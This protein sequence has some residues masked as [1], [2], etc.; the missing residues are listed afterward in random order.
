MLYSSIREK[1]KSPICDSYRT[2]FEPLIWEHDHYKH[3]SIE[4]S[5]SVLC[6]TIEFLI[7]VL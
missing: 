1:K 4:K 3:E 6:A 5:A 2:V 7:G